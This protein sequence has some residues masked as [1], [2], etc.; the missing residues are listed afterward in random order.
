ML[1]ILLRKYI[2]RGRLKIFAIKAVDAA[3]ARGYALE[4]GI[5][6]VSGRTSTLML[7]EVDHLMRHGRHQKIRGFDHSDRDPDF[8]QIR[9]AF[10][11]AAE[12]SK[13]VARAHHPKNE[14]IRMRKIHPP[15]RQC[16]AQIFIGV[17]QAIGRQMQPAARAGF[18]APICRPFPH[19]QF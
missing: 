17:F 7:E 14:I 1:D 11:P 3:D 16:P 8:V 18:G 12:M 10:D 2:R 13:A 9:H 19:A 5:V 6:G 15:E 4:F